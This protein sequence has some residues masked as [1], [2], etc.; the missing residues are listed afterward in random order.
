MH[1]SRPEYIL[2]SATT[3]LFSKDELKDDPLPFPYRKNNCK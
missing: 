2:Q 1:G 3:E